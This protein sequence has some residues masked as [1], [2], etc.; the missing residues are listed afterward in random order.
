MR[1]NTKLILLFITITLLTTGCEKNSDS[2]DIVKIVPENHSLLRE[3]S[4][5][6]PEYAINEAVINLRAGKIQDAITILEKITMYYPQNPVAQFQLGRAYYLNNEFDKFLHHTKQAFLADRNFAREHAGPI[7]GKDIVGRVFVTKEKDEEK[8][9]AL[10]PSAWFDKTIPV[11]Y[12][13]VE[14]INAPKGTEIETELIYELSQAETIKVNS[15]FFKI[16]GS[17][18]AVISVKQPDAGWPQGKYRLNV[19]VNG[20]KNTDLN[21]Y[22]F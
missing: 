9:L 4:E 20:T 1:L 3:F 18:N 6:K 12:A 5:L 15:V 11:I 19:Y 22:V 2:G 17:K 14:I 10:K 7:I 21:F 16:E 13:S 8:K